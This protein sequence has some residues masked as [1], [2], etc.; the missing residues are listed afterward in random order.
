MQHM[1]VLVCGWAQC[2]GVSRVG[3]NACQEIKVKYDSEHERHTAQR[4][5]VCTAAVLQAVD[6]QQLLC[7]LCIC[8]LCIAL[9]TVLMQCD[10]SFIDH[11]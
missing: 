7:V 10:T 8:W 11:R 3:S 6:R 1:L 2:V 5:G 4:A 9:T